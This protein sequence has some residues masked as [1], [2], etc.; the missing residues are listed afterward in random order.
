M[1][2]LMGSRSTGW[3]WLH[4]SGRRRGRLQGIVTLGTAIAASS[5]RAARRKHLGEG[6]RRCSRMPA[7]P[8]GLLV[9]Q[10]RTSMG[11]LRTGR[12]SVGRQCMWWWR[13]RSLLP[14]LV[15]CL[16]VAPSSN[17]Q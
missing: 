2:W 3:Q 17:T 11:P 13:R 12:A 14:P 4:S 6:W 5:T 10:A 15:V 8:L 16:Q 9:R 7:L 1:A